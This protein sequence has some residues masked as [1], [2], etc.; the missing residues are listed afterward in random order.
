M[1][2]RGRGEGLTGGTHVLVQYSYDV[3]RHTQEHQR[4]GLGNDLSYR[5]SPEPLSPGHTVPV[6]TPDG[7]TGEGGHMSICGTHSPHSIHPIITLC[8]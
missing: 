3:Q 8:Y 6:Q 2:E 1:A 5:R 7:Q 4:R